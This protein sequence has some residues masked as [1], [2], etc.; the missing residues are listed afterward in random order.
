M[1]VIVSWSG[2]KD[3]AFA[4]YELLKNNT[5]QVKGLLSTTSEES[6]RLPMHEV[7]TTFIYEQANA[8]GLPL[9]EVKLPA[10]ASNDV[11]EQALGEQMEYFKSMDIQNI[12]HA[13]LF[14]EDIKAY[15]DQQ[16]AKVGMQ[17]VYP[18]WRKDTLK[19]AEDFISEGFQAVVTTV[20]TSKLPG[21]MAGHPF[22]ETFIRTLP[23]GTDPCGEN[24]EFHTFVFDGPI[25]NHPVAVKTG[26]R[27]ETLGGRFA[28][29]ELS[30]R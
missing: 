11:Y 26:S 18:L 30:K 5:F 12:A 24:G 21:E 10:N 1:N 8:L 28:H 15:R 20:D 19:V 4:A 2:G 23:K 14:L 29:V 9:Y 22:D 25:Y 7:K 27:F 13:D 17:A 3:S 6:G 16:L